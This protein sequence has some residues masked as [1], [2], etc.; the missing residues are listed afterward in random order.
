MELDRLN[1]D[2]SN[3]ENVCDA[4]LEVLEF[5]GF[6][7]ATENYE[8]Y[9]SKWFNELLAS[10]G[11]TKGEFGY[12][13]NKDKIDS[14]HKEANIYACKHVIEDC[15]ETPEEFSRMASSCRWSRGAE[16]NPECVERLI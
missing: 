13:G 5:N 2:T 10:N 9:F 3:I 14:I 12:K 4:I 8:T 15:C 11:L 7:G 1:W 16:D 6:D